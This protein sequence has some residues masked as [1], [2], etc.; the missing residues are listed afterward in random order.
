MKG[1]GEKRA[2]KHW[3][4][5]V[6]L[7]FSHIYSVLDPSLWNGIGHFQRECSSVSS[8]HWKSPCS[9]PK[10]VL[11]NDP[12]CP[13]ILIRLTTEMNYEYVQIEIMRPG[14]S[15]ETH[16]CFRSGLLPSSGGSVSCGGWGV[17]EELERQHP[18]YVSRGSGFSP[19]HPGSG[20]GS[21]VTPVPRDLMPCSGIHEHQACM[22]HTDIQ[23]HAGT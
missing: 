21:S 4:T 17:R 2:H 5:G 15:R 10:E 13:W 6:L 23:I 22:W 20:W 14:H 1:G 18:V 11:I 3:Y 19:Q 9:L 8:P 16:P 12:T 7:V